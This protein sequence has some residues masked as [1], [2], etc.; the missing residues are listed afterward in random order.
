MT[1]TVKR[2]R[3]YITATT[4]EVLSKRKNCVMKIQ[5]YVYGT[6]RIEKVFVGTN[7]VI[8]MTDSTEGVGGILDRDHKTGFV[9]T[10]DFLKR[11]N[12]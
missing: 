3:V 11:V 4:L 12:V 1:R 2:L 7:V 10:H 6:F 8:I 5:I 9:F